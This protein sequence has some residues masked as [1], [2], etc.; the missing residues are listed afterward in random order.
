MVI[1]LS[2]VT[3]KLRTICKDISRSILSETNCESTPENGWLEDECPFR[4]ASFQV[5]N[6]GFREGMVFGFNMLET[7]VLRKHS[8]LS[9]QSI[10]L[11][12]SGFAHLPK[13][14]V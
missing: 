6:V 9:Y 2:C 11:S 5:R 3:M 7:Q 1:G 12:D 4:M 8:I 10:G 13:Y 14:R